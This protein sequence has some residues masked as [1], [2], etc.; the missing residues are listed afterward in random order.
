MSTNRPKSL[1]DLLS[2]HGSSLQK[3]A[4]GAADRLALTDHLR[5][6]L[7]PALAAHLTGANLRD[8]GTLVVLA[9]NPEWA[10]RLR[11]ESDHL[12]ACCRDRYR[13]AARV[14]IRVAHAGNLPTNG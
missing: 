2:S 11:F 10:A 3:L 1:S 5:G 13:Q 14:R 4:A 7:E 12:L 9:S 6:A 8:D